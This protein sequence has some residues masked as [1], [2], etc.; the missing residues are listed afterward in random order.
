[1]LGIAENGGGLMP[2]VTFWTIY[3]HPNDYP[4]CWV[5]RAHEVSPN[6]RIVQ[7][8][9]ACF[10]AATLDGIRAKVPPGACCIGRAPEDYPVI[11]ECWVVETPGPQRRH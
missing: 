2:Q 6:I 9:D 4:G 5:L 11:Y 8:H 10:V 3:R 7:S 1:L